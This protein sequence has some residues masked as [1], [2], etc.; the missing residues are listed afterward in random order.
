MLLA[1]IPAKFPIPWANSAGGSFTR[2]IPVTSQIGTTNG[3]ASLTDG[4]PPLNFL[5]VGS[6]GVPP[7]GR[8]VNGILKQITLWSQWAGAGGTVIFDGT[9]A[10]AIGGYPRGSVLHSSSG[11]FLWMS[12]IDNNTGD[13]DAG[14]PGWTQQLSLGVLTTG[15]WKFRPTPENLLSQGWVTANATTIGSAASGA[16]QWA[17]AS[18]AALFTYLWQNF[19]NAQCPVSGGRGANAAADFAA[20]KTIA[21]PDS[22]GLAMMGMDT[23]GGGATTYLSGVP[24]T[25][26]NATT[27]GSLLGENLHALITSELAAHN[28]G[29]TDPGHAHPPGAGASAFVVLFPGGA[30]L[31]NPAGTTAGS[32][33]NTG[34]AVTGI[35]TQSAGSGAAHNNVPRVMLVTWYVKT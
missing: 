18:A 22:R 32:L 19:S 34:S 24:V 16:T 30:A 11:D 21:T 35:S 1:S 3:A 8:D 4:F 12:T 6:G 9:F 13:P 7:D 17:N 15:D 29:V 33:A 26:G 27:A 23:M 2:A 5:P 14:A 10:T 25:S 20:N 31:A 28:H